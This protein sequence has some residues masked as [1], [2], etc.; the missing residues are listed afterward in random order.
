[1]INPSISNVEFQSS[2]GYKSFKIFL[3]KKG[4]KIVLEIW[5]MK[6]QLILDKE[7][8]PLNDISAILQIAHSEIDRLPSQ[9]LAHRKKS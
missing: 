8:S 4:L 9:L 7:I 2:Y 5:N 3:R 1:M 6:D